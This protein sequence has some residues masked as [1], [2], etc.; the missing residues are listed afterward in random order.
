MTS[1]AKPMKQAIVADLTTL[2]SA[3]LKGVIVDDMS[4][5]NPLDR[6]YPGFPCAVVI[7]PMVNTSEYEDT[8]NNT[9]EYEWMVMIID[10]PANVQAGDSYYL[11]DLIDAVL[12]VFDQ[13]CTLKGGG[14][15]AS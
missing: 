7:P 10:T 12:N 14:S 1:F 13:D 5:V 11:E 2:V 9:R 4:K 15:T 3:T 8:A 6:E